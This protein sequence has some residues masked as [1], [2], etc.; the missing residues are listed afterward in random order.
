MIHF[1][2]PLLL[3]AIAVLAAPVYVPNADAAVCLLRSSSGTCKYWS[4]SVEC[5]DLNASKLGNVTMDPKYMSC[6][7][8]PTGDQ[9]DGLD[10]L[11]FCSN[12]GDNV[13][14]GRQAFLLGPGFSG[15]TMI[16]EYQVQKNGFA[17]EIDVT[18]KLSE[19][20]LYVLDQFCQNDNWYAVDFV[21]CAMDVTVAV[22]DEE[23]AVTDT[24]QFSCS[25]PQCDTLA[26]DKL[27]QRPERR[28]YECSEL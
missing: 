25:L 6:G 9:P 21:P 2:K 11:V 27:Q 18:A 20:G 7:V 1:E 28:Q 12:G 5:D 4:G 16:S 19:E 17:S 24:K 8:S 23:G 14:P 26:W 15:M 13:A 10:G 3:I 22:V